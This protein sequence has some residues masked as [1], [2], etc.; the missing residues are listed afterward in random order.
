MAFDTTVSPKRSRHTPPI[1]GD[2]PKVFPVTGRNLSNEKIMED[3]TPSPQEFA[4]G[5]LAGQLSYSFQLNFLPYTLKNGPR[6]V[7]LL[8]F[9]KIVQISFSTTKRDSTGPLIGRLV[10]FLQAKKNHLSIENPLVV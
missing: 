7:P 8:R 3:F 9:V 4:V 6:T 2:S 1:H 5:S 10:V